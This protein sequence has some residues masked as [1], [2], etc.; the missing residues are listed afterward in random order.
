L[1]AT[2]AVS[3]LLA[4]GARAAEPAAPATGEHRYL[5]VGKAPKDRDGFRTM[6]PSI[7]VHDIDDGHKLVKVLPIRTPDGTPPLMAI[8]GMMAHAP[9]RRLYLS[10]YASMKDSRSGWLLC[11]D[12][13]TGEPIWHKRYD[14]AVDRGAITPDGKK[15]YMPSGETVDT[16]YFYVID[17]ETGDEL[18]D[19]RIATP[20]KTHNT[21][22]S[23]DGTKVFMSMFGAKHDH[24][25][26]MVADTRT[27]RIIQKVGPTSHIVR[28]FTI[29]GEASLAFMTVNA[30]LGFQVGDVATGKILHTVVPPDA[31]QYAQPEHKRITSHGIAL[32]S[33]EREVW[34]VDQSRRS[35]I[36]VFDVTG[37]PQKPPVWTHFID[38][39]T[40]REKDEHG[41]NLYE[42]KGAFGQPG[43]LMGT[44]DGR[45][46]YPETGEI[47]DTKTKR[48]LGNLK[49][50]NGLY[51]HSRFMLEVDFKDDLPIRAGDQ[52]IVGR[53]T[54]T[55]KATPVVDPKAS[56]RR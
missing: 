10:H 3:V 17:A 18:R 32:T 35:G 45:Y 44:I 26:L 24:L 38:T 39:K 43:W 15:I 53:V 13:V 50:A 46:I 40:G 27:D 16:E 14:S 22:V 48:V 29:N 33:D 42:D 23:L 5:Y 36:H 11:A 30:L 31:E 6:V 37:L 49:G 2:L 7:E 8:R 55:A 21:I 56:S 25:Y 52:F 34:V 28:P 19:R 51:T 41:N 12:L 4:A 47:I 9:S 1:L 54:R 20:G